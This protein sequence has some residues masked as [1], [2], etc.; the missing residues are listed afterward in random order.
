MPDPAAAR[1][2]PD[3]SVT[4]GGGGEKGSPVWRRRARVAGATPVSLVRAL[5][6]GPPALLIH[7]LAEPPF[8]AVDRF[9]PVGRALGRV[10]GSPLDSLVCSI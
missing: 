2:D 10:D 7:V 5:P 1:S 9:M 4:L 3:A 8:L 6:A